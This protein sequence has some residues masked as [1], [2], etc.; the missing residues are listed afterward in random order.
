MQAQRA[1]APRARQAIFS[2][3]SGLRRWHP[4]VAS[5]ISRGAC[6]FQTLEDDIGR[7]AFRKHLS[8][9]V[10]PFITLS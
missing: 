3:S 2:P 4:A 7:D 10:A 6:A 1:T 9:S 5:L 8:N